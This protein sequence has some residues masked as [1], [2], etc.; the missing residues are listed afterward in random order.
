MATIV[1]LFALAS[2]ATATASGQFQ[3][4]PHPADGD[5]E[6][7]VFVGTCTPEMNGTIYTPGYSHNDGNPKTWFFLTNCAQ[8]RRVVGWVFY[9]NYM[10]T[11]RHFCLDRGATDYSG[12][13]YANNS[14]GKPGEF[15]YYLYEWRFEYGTCQEYWAEFYENNPPA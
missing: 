15:T 1:A 10:D 12:H 3:A 6:A 8:N 11:P 14:A 5:P 7:P 9:H 13:K 4:P 2:P